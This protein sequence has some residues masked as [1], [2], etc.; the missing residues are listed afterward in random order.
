MVFN[1]FTERQE[2][3][4]MKQQLEFTKAIWMISDSFW[5]ERLAETTMDGFS[6]KW[7]R[8]GLQLERIP[9]NPQTRSLICGKFFFQSLREFRA[10]SW[11]QS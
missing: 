2:I 9:G 5:G 11:N 1:A 4:E 10:Y 3:V 6:A 7:L 8:D